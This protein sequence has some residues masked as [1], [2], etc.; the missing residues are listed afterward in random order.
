M[1]PIFLRKNQTDKTKKVAQSTSGIKIEKSMNAGKPK[2]RLLKKVML[3]TEA[4]QEKTETNGVGAR[5][6]TIGR[7]VTSLRSMKKLARQTEDMVGPEKKKKKLKHK[8]QNL[9]NQ[10]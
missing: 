7:E 10:L 2:N 3:L 9:K 5:N 1:T 4:L 6:A 8:F